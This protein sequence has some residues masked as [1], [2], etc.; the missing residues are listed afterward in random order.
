MTASNQDQRSLA[1]LISARVVALV[2]PGTAVCAGLSGGLDSVVLLDA[3]ADLR[4]EGALALRA[5]HVHHGLSPNAE[6]WAQFCAQLCAARQVPLLVERVAVDRDSPLGLEAAAREARYRV[7]SSQGAPVV[8]LAHH[9]DDQAETVLLQLL[10]GTGLKGVAAMPEWRVL[11]DTQVALL[12]P[13]LA[14]SRAELLAH[15]RARDLEWIEDE[16]NDSPAFDRNFLRLEVAPVLDE[17][18]P[19]WKDALARFARHAA[20]ADGLLQSIARDD[21]ALASQALA[22]EGLRSQAPERQGNALRAF[23]EANALPMPSEARLSEMAR[24]LFGARDDARVRIEHAGAALVRHRDEILVDRHERATEPWSLA[25]DGTDEIALGAQRGAVRF[26]RATGE[27]IAERLTHDA[28]WRFGSRDGGERIRLDAARPTRTLKNL[29][30][31][32]D[33]P[34]W[35]RARLPLLFHGDALVWVP[36]IGVAAGYRCP[37][38]EPGRVPEWF[39]GADP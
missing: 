22:I 21:G 5:V 11:R 35:Q 18:F 6:R 37:A 36:G 29:L 16:S 12:R 10:R 23:L 30:Q 31:E 39:F 13:L 3:L 1:P 32:H 14:F 27:G 38:G 2:A 8:A 9:L 15:A 19:R 34:V 20:A 26:S 28:L 4:D 17:R 25:W 33:V 7:F 24:Q